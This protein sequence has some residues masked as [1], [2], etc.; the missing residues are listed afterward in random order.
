MYDAPNLEVATG[1]EG[2]D[3][4]KL[5]TK[6]LEERVYDA[7]RDAIVAGDFRPG[8]PLVEAQ[9]SERFGISKTPVRE[10]LIRLKR[11]GLVEASLHRVNRV[12][13]PSADRIQQAFEVRSWIESALAARAAEAPSSALLRDLKASIDQAREALAAGDTGT[14]VQCVR[15]FS[16]VIVAAGGNDYAD[17][18]L[19]RLRDVLALIAHIS[20]E[21]PGRRERSIEE[22]RAIYLAIKR[23]D[24]AGAAE[25][26]KRHLQSIQQDSLQ[27]LGQL[28]A[29]G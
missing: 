29:T 19:D 10:A 18:L 14:Y 25:A 16:D 13:T 26:T 23:K 2:M 22:H 20:R 4:H 21:T 6:S 5:T 28:Q 3:S 24:P 17:E 1:A 8:D 12:A 15:R 11:D 27:A 9:L 7:L